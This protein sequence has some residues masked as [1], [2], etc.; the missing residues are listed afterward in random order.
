MWKR[1]AGTVSYNREQDVL[2]KDLEKIQ[3]YYRMSIESFDKIIEKIEML[4]VSCS[5]A[6]NEECLTI[7]FRYFAVNVIQF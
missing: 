2:R 5:A 3:R 1:V 4:P 7:T 6:C